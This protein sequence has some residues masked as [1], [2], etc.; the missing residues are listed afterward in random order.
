MFIAQLWRR[1]AARCR[2]PCWLVAECKKNVSTSL[3]HQQ[4]L[5]RPALVHRTIPFGHLFERQPEVEDLAGINLAIP[6]Q[7]N[8]LG[9]EAPHRRGT[10]EQ[11]NLRVE[12]L[13]SWNLDV[14]RNADE[15]DVTDRS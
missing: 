10:A 9:Q 12:Q 8:Q 7:I 5:D 14:V 2:R 4:R 1:P 13:Q 6:D 3:R 11:V 15:A